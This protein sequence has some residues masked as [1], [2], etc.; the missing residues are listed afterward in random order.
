MKQQRSGPNKKGYAF[1]LSLLLLPAVGLLI[2]GCSNKLEDINA[3]LNPLDIPEME[4]RDI[5]ITRTDSGKILFIATAPYVIKYNNNFRNFIEFP[6]GLHV[7]SFEPYPD[8]VSEMH[9]GYAKYFSEKNL[10]EARQGVE[11]SN[12]AG[13]KL[14]TEVLFWDQTK[15]ILYSDVL[16][17]IVTEDGVFYGRKGFE[18]DD[19]FKK[20]KLINTEGTVNVRDE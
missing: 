8:T 5:K 19:R 1:L 11:A 13:E 12:D 20:W 18:S 15:G 4:A 16:T 7:Y 9:A 6:E 17:T 2:T 10:W 14:L 3:L